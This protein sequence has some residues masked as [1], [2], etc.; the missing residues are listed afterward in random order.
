ML[1]LN[2]VRYVLVF[3]GC[4]FGLVGTLT[5]PNRDVPMPPALDLSVPKDHNGVNALLASAR[6]TR[7][8]IL[9]H[10]IP[11]SRIRDE[12]SKM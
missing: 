9:N 4:I 3:I 10:E 2:N 6:S 8:D 5:C 12:I 11:Y 1:Y 7:R